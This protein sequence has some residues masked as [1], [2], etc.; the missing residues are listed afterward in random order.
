MPHWRKAHEP[1]W[2]LNAFALWIIT[3]SGFLA[4]IVLIARHVHT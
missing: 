1:T 4:T 3:T 2:R